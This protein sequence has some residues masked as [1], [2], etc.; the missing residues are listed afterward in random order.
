VIW[1]LPGD[2]QSVVWPPE[3]ELPP[4]VSQPGSSGLSSPGIADAAGAVSRAAATP[5]PAPNSEIVRRVVFINRSSRSRGAFLSLQG[6]R[7]PVAL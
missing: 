7:G 6:V 2:A 5:M 4:V 3:M 1:E